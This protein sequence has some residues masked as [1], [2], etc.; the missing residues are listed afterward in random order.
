MKHN[1]RCIVCEHE[2]TRT[3]IDWKCDRSNARHTVELEL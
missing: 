1:P 2:M 3:K